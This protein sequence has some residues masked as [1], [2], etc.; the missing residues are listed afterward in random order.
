MH[1]ISFVEKGIRSVFLAQR[2]VTARDIAP[3]AI[4]TNQSDKDHAAERYPSFVNT[5]AE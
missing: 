1:G 4:E 2:I 5:F 3:E